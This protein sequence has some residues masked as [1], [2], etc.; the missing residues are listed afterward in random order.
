ML[1]K[2]WKNFGKYSISF[3]ENC[4]STLYLFY[5]IYYMWKI[6]II[7]FFGKMLVKIFS[8]FD[9]ILSRRNKITMQWILQIILDLVD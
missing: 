4:V 9:E 8:N 3:L 2:G 7:H 5:E 1:V 6:F